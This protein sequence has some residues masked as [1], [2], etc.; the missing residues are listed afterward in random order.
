[1]SRSPLL[2]VFIMCVY[3]VKRVNMSRSPLFDVFI[4]VCTVLYMY[5]YMNHLCFVLPP[6]IESLKTPY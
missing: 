5:L 6:V 1:M 4:Y 2:H 3:Y